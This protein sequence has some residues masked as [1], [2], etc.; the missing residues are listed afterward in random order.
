MSYLYTAFNTSINLQHNLQ[1]SW[2]L[3]TGQSTESTLLKMTKQW[4]KALDNGKVV[5]VLFI[6]LKKAFDVVQHKKLLDGS[7]SLT[8]AGKSLIFQRKVEVRTEQ[9]TPLSTDARS[10]LHPFTTVNC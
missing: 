10:K 6:D 8:L 3:R 9:R 1:Q 5:A 7:P 2:G 4:N